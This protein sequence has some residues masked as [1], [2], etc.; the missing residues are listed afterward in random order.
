[1][2]NKLNSIKPKIFDPG[3]NTPPDDNC[4]LNEEE[5]WK[6]DGT[7]KVETKQFPDMNPDSQS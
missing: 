3:Q 4:G 5:E 2:F 1:M 7:T 6:Q